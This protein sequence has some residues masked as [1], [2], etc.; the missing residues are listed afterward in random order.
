MM[1]NKGV[2]QFTYCLCVGLVVILVC[3]LVFCFCNASM[4]P[5]TET[6]RCTGTYSHPSC[7]AHTSSSVALVDSGELTHLVSRNASCED[8]S[9]EKRDVRLEPNRDIEVGER[10]WAEHDGA[11][12]KATVI[13]VFKKDDTS[14]LGHSS[15][16]Y[17]SKRL[18]PTVP[19]VSM[20]TRPNPLF[21]YQDE[22]D[23]AQQFGHIV[24]LQ[25][26]S[27][28]P[29]SESNIVK[30]VLPKSTHDQVD[31]M[32]ESQ[33]INKA[34]VQSNTLDLRLTVGTQVKRMAQ[35]TVVDACAKGCLDQH[36]HTW[37]VEVGGCDDQLCACKCLVHDG[38]GGTCNN[39]QTVPNEDIQTNLQQNTLFDLHQIDSTKKEQYLMHKRLTTL[40]AS[41]SAPKPTAPQPFPC[42]PAS[43]TGS[44]RTTP[45]SSQSQCCAN[46][47]DQYTG[48]EWEYCMD[49]TKLKEFLNKSPTI[50]SV[51][52]GMCFGDATD[53]PQDASC[54][55]NADIKCSKRTEDQCVTHR[56]SDFYKC[57]WHTHDT[58]DELDKHG[59]GCYDRDMC[60]FNASKKDC[61][62]NHKC[63]WKESA[64][65]CVEKA[66]CPCTTTTTQGKCTQNPFCRWTG[67]ECKINNVFDTKELKELTKHHS[68]DLR[69][70]VLQ[71]DAPIYA[72]PS[73]FNEPP[74]VPVTSETDLAGT[75][76]DSLIQSQIDRLLT[77]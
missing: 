46:K 20:L 45:A 57:K 27:R 59:T 36:P 34:R 10:V 58:K 65:R 33:T 43:A 77:D 26:F 15:T 54:T 25:N 51:G 24:G 48:K 6:F 12:H 32:F 7:Q 2:Q 18:P 9:M 22:Y 4:S 13:R 44:T 19:P 31:V 76:G 66:D 64:Q 37:G 23:K 49:H 41:C 67:T 74:I 35:S 3:A 68:G 5:T 21:Y 16:Q 73:S 75:I 71:D 53:S 62:I 63:M 29:L 8:P 55:P 61:E 1:Q 47:C 38:S 70:D 52:G 60:M 40:N 72:L 30:R 69:Y 28:V 39:V 42:T 17:D 50:T 14:A 56:E 11:F